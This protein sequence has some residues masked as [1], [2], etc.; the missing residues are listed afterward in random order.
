MTT[1]QTHGSFLTASQHLQM[2]AILRKHG[3]EPGHPSKDR[4]EQM[5]M[6]HETMAK[7]RE[8]QARGLG[9]VS[10]KINGIDVLD[11]YDHAIMEDA[12]HYE[13]TLDARRKEI[14]LIDG[15][16]HPSGEPARATYD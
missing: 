6:S 8:R 2:A 5:A 11:A 13:G 9:S 12:D 10:K 15:W 14:G 4:A 7:I 3:G 1:I 16:D